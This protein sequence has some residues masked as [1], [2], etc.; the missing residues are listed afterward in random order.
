MSSTDAV[1]AAD[2]L[3]VYWRPGCYFCR[4]LLRALDGAGARVRLHNIWEDEDARAFVRAHN[5][6]DETVPTVVLGGRVSTN[7]SPREFLASLRAEH[8]SLLAGT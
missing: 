7:P 8:P 5:N 2:A 6:G 4:K 1:P 3:D